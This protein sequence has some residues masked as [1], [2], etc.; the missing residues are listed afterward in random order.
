M[1][2]HKSVISNSLDTFF[3]ESVGKKYQIFQSVS[4]KIKNPIPYIFIIPVFIKQEV[5]Q[6]IWKSN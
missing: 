2:T 5:K 1:Q 6:N 4:K 3:W